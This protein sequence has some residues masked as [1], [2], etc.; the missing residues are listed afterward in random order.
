M[1][2]NLHPGQRPPDWTPPEGIKPAKSLPGCMKIGLIVVAVFVGLAI[3]GAIISPK[4]NGQKSAESSPSGSPEPAATAN[5]TPT[6]PASKWSYSEQ[7]DKV[8]AGTDF[9]ATLVSENRIH[10]DF[11]YEDETSGRIT[12]RK[13]ASG[14]T[15]VMFQVSSGQLMCPSY[16]GCRGTVK[17]DNNPAERVSFNGPSDNSNETVFVVGAKGFLAKLKKSKR[18]VI[19]KTMFQAGEPQ[20]EFDT[21]GLKWEH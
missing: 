4:P 3:F 11:P 18:V 6:A 17:F 20:F 14:E 5:A 1:A 16:E 2:N 19:E 12:I 9:F 15:D 7:E 13:A 21:T 8:R 10:Q